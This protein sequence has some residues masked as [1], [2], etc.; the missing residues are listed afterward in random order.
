MSIISLR[1]PHLRVA[2]FWRYPGHMP[3][4]QIKNVPDDVHAAL[5]RSARSA[6][7]SMQEFLLSELKAIAE[8]EIT[9][10]IFKSARERTVDISPQE[11]VRIIR[12]DREPLIVVDSSALINGLVAA[13]EGPS[14]IRTDF[15]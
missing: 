4:I 12:E 15:P 13:G 14:Q 5:Q 1:R 11:I 6:G 8:Q 10:E 3:S 2:P 7:Q 9:A